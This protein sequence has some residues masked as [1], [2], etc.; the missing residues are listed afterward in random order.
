MALNIPFVDNPTPRVVLKML[1]LEAS[2]LSLPE[3]QEVMKGALAAYCVLQFGAQYFSHSLAPSLF[4]ALSST[5]FLYAATLYLLRFLKQDALF[6]K[7]LSALAIMGALG[8]GAYIVLHVIVGIALPPPLPTERL[9]RFLLFPII[10][11]LVFIYAFIFRH[12]SMRNIPAFV[13]GALYVLAIEIVLSA[14][15]F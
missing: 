13:T 15:N 6:V 12:V 7:T 3:S 9:A 1:N 14:V 11:W 2:H 10:V 8:A 4:Y 5:G